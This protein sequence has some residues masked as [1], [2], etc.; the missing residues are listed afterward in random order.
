MCCLF[1]QKDFLALTSWSGANCFCPDEWIIWVGRAIC[2]EEFRVQM[3]GSVASG[4]NK[5]HRHWIWL[6]VMGRCEKPLWSLW[7]VHMR[8]WTIGIKAMRTGASETS[9]WMICFVSRADPST[10]LFMDSA[11]QGLKQFP[12]LQ[13]ASWTQYRLCILYIIW[14]RCSWPTCSS[15]N[16]VMNIVWKDNFF[17]AILCPCHKFWQRLPASNNYHRDDCGTGCFMA[18][19]PVFNKAINPVLSLLQ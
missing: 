1:F 3:N 9:G 16:L 15:S 8:I 11:Y 17:R 18:P 2:S 6:Q 5:Q 14:K 13:L 10:N 7:R 12:Y 19:V 4:F